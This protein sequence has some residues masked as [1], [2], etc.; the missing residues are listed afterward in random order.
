MQ[1]SATT[2]TKIPPI[3][4]PKPKICQLK[5]QHG[6]IAK[7][8][9]LSRSTAGGQ[10]PQP[11]GDSDTD[12][13]ICADSDNQ[14]SPRHINV[15]FLGDKSKK[16]Q[17]KFEIPVYREHLT[18]ENAWYDPFTLKRVPTNLSKLSY[19]RRLPERLQMNCYNGQTSK[20]G[21]QYRVRFADQV[22]STDGGS[23]SSSS[24][25]DNTDL[26]SVTSCGSNYSD[27]YR[28]STE[29]ATTTSIISANNPDQVLPTVIS[30]NSN[31]VINKLSGQ[32][33][34]MDNQ[35]SFGYNCHS[36]PKHQYQINGSY[37]QDDTTSAPLPQSPGYYS[38]A[39]TR[40][41][42][43]D[44]QYLTHSNEPFFRRFH[45]R[46]VSLP[47]GIHRQSVT[48]EIRRGSIDCS[49]SQHDYSSYMS[50]DE[51]T[52]N[53]YLMHSVDNLSITERGQSSLMNDTSLG[54]GRRLPELP[55]DYVA[56]DRALQQSTFSNQRRKIRKAGV[57]GRSQNVGRAS[58]SFDSKMTSTNSCC[59]PSL[60]QSHLP[61]VR[62]QLIALDHRG[63]R[64]VLIEKLQPGPFG[65]YVA[66]G[67]LNQK[68][69]IFISRVSLPS[70]APV[71]S[72]G[73]E[74][75]YV[76]DELVKGEDLEYVQALIAGKSSVKIV[77]LPTVGPSIC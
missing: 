56:Y 35:F 48:L 28:S 62:A 75:I 54:S 24:C 40:L 33:C 30:S 13:G 73:D 53:A 23:S 61:S 60:H 59:I 1:N 8:G 27:C 29:A 2:L 3:P 67:I 37:E 15:R 17:H 21:K 66:T 70:L 77:L 50:E 52:S 71:L 9:K 12:S 31:R 20:N 42:R 55:I 57:N 64:I 49:N 25:W 46:S 41:R 34:V 38:M 32:Q 39:M 45:N 76:E 18:P 14:L 72:V 74:I 63:L 19:Q 43:S 58:H 68:H 65:F 26:I 4:A 36:Q 16:L 5:Y 10:L 69:G 44:N 6:Q 22:S 47:R 7:F 11:P 51:A